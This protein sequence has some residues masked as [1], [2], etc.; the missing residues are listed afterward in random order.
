[1]R[2]REQTL[3]PDVLTRLL[4]IGASAAVVLVALMAFP[5]VAHAQQLVCPPPG[6]ASCRPI[7]EVD[8]QHPA[9]ILTATIAGVGSGVL[10][11]SAKNPYKGASDNANKGTDEC[12]TPGS[13]TGP[14][15]WDW[16]VKRWCGFHCEHWHTLVN[17]NTLGG[18]TPYQAT[19]I[20]TATPDAGS[21]FV[22]WEPG[23]CTAPT[24]PA[25]PRLGCAVVMSA[26][27]SVQANLS[28]TADAQAPTA[29]VIAKGTVKRYSIQITW[30]T[31]ATDNLWLGGYEI[32]RNGNLYA[33]RGPT[34]PGITATS[35]LCNTS[36]TWRV[37]AFDSANV[38]SS[39]T[40]V[41]KTGKCAKVPPNTVIHVRPPRTTRQ[42]SAYFHWGAVRRGQELAHFKSQCK[43]GKKRWKKCFPGKTYRNLKP[44]YRTVRIRVGDSQGWDRTPA[45]VRWLVKG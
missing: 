30:P 29:P 2:V 10:Q 4:V 5:K 17:P 40:I 11:G 15:T 26:N 1:M 36:Y 7:C 14:T 12:A 34:A 13:N 16:T 31:P 24:K 41:V 39:N 8:A 42:K 25:D 22:G 23:D 9:S 35:L 28:D 19:A 18:G 44:G 20:V 6:H 33:R 3:R 32:Y 37:D 27:K 45:K 43:I 38:T 21:F